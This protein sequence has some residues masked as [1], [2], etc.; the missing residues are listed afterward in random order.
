[1]GKSTSDKQQ[2]VKIALPFEQAIKKIVKV[3]DE[4]TKKQAKKKK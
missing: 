2:K 3:A 1:M 4:K